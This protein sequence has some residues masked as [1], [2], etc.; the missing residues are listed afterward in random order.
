MSSTKSKLRLAGAFAALVTLALAMSCRGFFVKPTLS[1][2]TV[3]PST[4]TID[5]GTTNNTVQMTAT[6]NFNDGS[7]GSASVAWGIAPA[8]TGGPQAAT[9]STGGL[10][11]ASTTT[12]GAMTVTAT[13]LQNGTLTATGAVNVQPPNLT[14]ITIMGSGTTALQ[15]GTLNF[16]AK[17]ISGTG[18]FD[19]TQIV[20]W[21]SSNTAIAMIAAG[22]VM[23]A[24]S[25]GTGGTTVISATLEGITSNNPITVTVSQ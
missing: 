21:N 5:A 22:G 1:S 23:T 17:G 13:A 18:N 9:I 10:V 19:I 7:T 3:V 4:S 8:T 20:T 14:S 16:T 6:A 25:T 2:I 11:T 24:N 12:V 15:G